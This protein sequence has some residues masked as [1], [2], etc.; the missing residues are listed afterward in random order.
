MTVRFPRAT[1]LAVSGALLL[2]ACGGGDQREAGAAEKEKAEA[3]PA[4]T[5]KVIVVTA[6]TDEKGS[7]F[8][9]NRIEAHQGDILQFTLAV[10]VHNVNF[11]PDSNT[12]KT[13]LPAPSDM[14]QLPGQTIEIPLTFGTGTFYFQCDPHAALGM[15]GRVKV[16][17]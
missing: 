3:A 7:Y 11:L 1:R 16:E 10:G 5:G 9:P 15:N 4:A 13:G 2:A 12:V 8:S 6:T 17:D 14:L